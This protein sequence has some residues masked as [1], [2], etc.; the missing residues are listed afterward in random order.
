MI[1]RSLA[2]AAAV[3]FGLTAPA[4]AQ[5]DPHHPADTATTTLDAATTVAQAGEPATPGGTDSAMP[6][7]A[8]P[9]ATGQ[10]AAC[11]AGAMTPQMMEQMMPMMQ[12]MMMQS[13]P[14]AQQMMSMMQM[15]QMMQSTQQEMM[16]TM[17]M[18]QQQMMTM[19][20][21]QG[22]AASEDKAEP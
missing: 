1:V 13:M 10:T 5:T 9:S 4:L 19:Q 11:P 2:I 16:K 22:P 6:S 7:S 17:Q 20:Q 3:L 15:M 8:M 21:M 18:M 14:M 12:Q